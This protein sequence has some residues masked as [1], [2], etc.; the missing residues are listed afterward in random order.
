MQAFDYRRPRTL[1][2]A[3][4]LLEAD[5]EA[6]PLAGG[7]T[8]IP[9]L[10]Q[11]LAAPSMLVDLAGVP[12]LKSIGEEDGAIRLGAM[13]THAEVAA[14]PVVRKAIPTLAELAE[15]IGDP[16]V[17]NRGAV[18]GSIANADPA[19]DYPAAVVGLAATV[20]TS[21]REIAGDD[22][23]TGLFETAL[24]PAELVTAVRFRIPDA[25]AYVKFPNPASR[26][27]AVG[28]FVARFGA[29]VRM[30]VTGAAPSV[31]RLIA[32]EAA[33]ERAFSP[34]V[35]GEDI[36]VAVEALNADGH[37]PADYRARLVAVMARRA[38]AA[39]L[40]RT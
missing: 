31:F 26:Y 5:P 40:A 2:E 30:A 14:S 7:M 1:N 15:G 10:K 6:V 18:G 22:F 28:V 29:E 3:L 24:E 37:A 21:R 33:L 27:A 4:A 36:E 20:I 16:H 9:T 32:T 34:E 19:A 12:E 38:V 11:R 25:A 39:C 8:L 35:I 17:R 13:V 23:F